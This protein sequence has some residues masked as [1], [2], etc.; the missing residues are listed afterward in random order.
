MITPRNNIL[1]RLLAALFL[2][3]AFSQPVLAL[4]VSGVKISD[5]TKVANKE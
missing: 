2:V 3:S 4:E 1:K 5:T